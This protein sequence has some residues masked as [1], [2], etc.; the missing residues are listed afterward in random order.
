M[1]TKVND[2]LITAWTSH[3]KGMTFD[4]EDIGRI[5]TDENIIVV[6]IIGL[7]TKYDHFVALIDA[8][9]TQQLMV[10]YVVTR[11]LNEEA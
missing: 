6:L 4:L 2:K 10:D 1:V 3:V 11:M 7:E 8:M 9:P 5:V